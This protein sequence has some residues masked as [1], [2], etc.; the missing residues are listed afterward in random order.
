MFDMVTDFHQ[1]TSLSR[2]DSLPTSAAVDGDD[3]YLTPV[4]AWATSGVGYVCM[5]NPTTE[6]REPSNLPSP[7]APHYVS[8]NDNDNGYLL[9][10]L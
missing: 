7:P 9:P 3:Q 8:D 5:T 4:N 6:D 10:V 1:Y 2:P